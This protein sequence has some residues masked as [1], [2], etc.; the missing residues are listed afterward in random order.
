M[1]RT[2]S[3]STF[4]YTAPIASSGTS[5]KT[6]VTSLLTLTV[7]SLDDCGLEPVLAGWLFPIKTENIKTKTNATSAKR[8]IQ[9]I[10]PLWSIG[11]KLNRR[12]YLHSCIFIK[13]HI[14]LNPIHMVLFWLQTLMIIILFLWFNLYVKNQYLVPISCF[15]FSFTANRSKYRFGT[16][17]C[18]TSLLF[19]F[20]FLS[21]LKSTYTYVH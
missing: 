7:V 4:T 9:R 5:S 11:A 19:I 14:E 20:I 13:L 10:A 16:I 12:R 17:C 6:D 15:P 21:K 18:F 8:R 3:S 1:L 2:Y